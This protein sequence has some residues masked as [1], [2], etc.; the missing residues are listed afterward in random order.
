MKMLVT[1]IL[2]GCILC[3]SV[4]IGVVNRIDAVKV[5]GR[6]A[7]VGVADALA[8]KEI[9]I[10]KGGL[11]VRM[12]ARNEKFWM[13]AEPKQDLMNAVAVRN[14]LS[15]I[16]NLTILETLSKSELSKPEMAL[17]NLGLDEDNEICLLYTSPSP[18]DQRG[19]RMPSSA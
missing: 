18:R 6:K 17:S 19:S 9:T 12:I 15:K 13:F 11:K 16:G 14:L 4:V 10:E 1:L 3:L 7:L 5:S 2:A 8:T